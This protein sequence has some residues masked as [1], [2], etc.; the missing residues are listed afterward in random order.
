MPE[1]LQDRQ[2]DRLTGVDFAK[3]ISTEQTGTG[4]AQNVAHTL[5][6]VPALV[7]V[8]PTKVATAG[9]TFVEGAHTASNFV[10]TV[11]TGSKFVIKAF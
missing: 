7:F 2:V 8:L 10:M 4:S 3:F 6:Y 11:S 9:D 5:G 1:R